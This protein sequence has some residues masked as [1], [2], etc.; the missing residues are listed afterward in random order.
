MAEGLGLFAE[1]LLVKVRVAVPD[2]V[3]HGFPL[4]DEVG[5]FLLKL[6]LIRPLGGLPQLVIDLLQVTLNPL[7]PAS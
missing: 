5:S 1:L 6:Y 7:K 2:L 4:L 3:E